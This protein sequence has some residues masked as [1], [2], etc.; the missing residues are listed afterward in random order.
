MIPHSQSAQLMRL[1]DCNH[2]FGRSASDQSAVVTG[3]FRPEADV[4]KRPLPA[5]SGP[6]H[7]TAGLPPALKQSGLMKI[8]GEYR[9]VDSDGTLI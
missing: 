1:T 4:G 8:G 3:R 5:I 9:A 7:A 6:S 2:Q